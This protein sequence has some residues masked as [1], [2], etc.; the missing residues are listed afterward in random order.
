[1]TG[2]HPGE[3]KL[4]LWL[5]TLQLQLIYICFCVQRRVG[6]AFTAK[7]E[8]CLNIKGALNLGEVQSEFSRSPPASRWKNSWR[9]ETNG[10]IPLN[11]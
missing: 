4:V 10:A 3:H 2:R 11:N 6:N 1:M 7:Q 5:C 8:G 9:G